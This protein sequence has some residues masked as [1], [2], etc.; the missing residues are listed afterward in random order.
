VLVVDAGEPRNAPADHVHNF[1]TRDGTPPP[2]IY[3]AGRAE[4]ARYGGHVRTGRV[5]ALSRDGDRFAVQIGDQAVTAR[6]LLVATGLRDELPDVPGLAERWGID[7]LHCPYCHGWEVRDQ[8]I[9][10]LAD[11]SGATSV[12]GVWVAGNLA[13]IAAQVITSAAAGLTAA[14]I[15]GDLAAEDAK[16]AVGAT[17]RTPATTASH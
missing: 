14:A 5:T 13:N 9:G 12:P 11:P 10:I 3:A 8:R 17:P 16:R 15:N 7:V 4:V 6:R 2:E 1:L